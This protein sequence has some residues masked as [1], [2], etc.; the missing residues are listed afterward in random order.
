[1]LDRFLH[2]A[3]GVAR[4]RLLTVLI[5]TTW[6]TAGAGLA[7][8]WPWALGVMIVGVSGF[9]VARGRWV[10]TTPTA[11]IEPDVAGRATSPALAQTQDRVLARL[12]GMAPAGDPPTSD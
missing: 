11:D 7:L 4:T 6:G 1:M 2:G 12:Q 5:A 9:T 10:P 8:G 3:T